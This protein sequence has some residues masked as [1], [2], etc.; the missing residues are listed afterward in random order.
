M[1]EFDWEKYCA[2][3]SIWRENGTLICILGTGYPPHDERHVISFTIDH[4]C[5]YPLTFK[6][7]GKNKAAFADTAT[8]FWSLKQSGERDTHLIV[9][10]DDMYAD[11]RDFDATVF[12]AEQ[13]ARILNSNPTRVFEFVTGTWTAEQSVIF[14]TRPYP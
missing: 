11:E 9:K 12:T 10:S 14:A 13:L 6:I 2:N 5:N 3:C 4:V 7:Y 8:F 1:N